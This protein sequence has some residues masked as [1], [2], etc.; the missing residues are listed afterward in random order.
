MSPS[1]SASLQRSVLKIGGTVGL[2][3]AAG[4]ALE[5][6]ALFVALFSI[7]GT[8]AV[9]S[10]LGWSHWEHTIVGGAPVTLR[11]VAPESL[12]AD[13]SAKIKETSK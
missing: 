8:A 13:V 6:G 3:V 9:M 10:G 11:T 7:A 5:N 4:L 12:P 1:V 2:T